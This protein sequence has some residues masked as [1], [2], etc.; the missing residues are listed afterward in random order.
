MTDYSLKQATWQM[1][2][3]MQ[4]WLQDCPHRAQWTP[5]THRKPT[6]R[7]TKPCSA[8]DVVC[9]LPVN[10]WNVDTMFG[11]VEKL[12]NHPENLLT[13]PLNTT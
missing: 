2:P 11:R 3:K 7:K 4:S 12:I 1:G 8:K 13:I 9:E 6:Y 5:P 10:L